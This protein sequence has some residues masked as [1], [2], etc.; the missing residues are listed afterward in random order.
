MVLA[1]GAAVAYVVAELCGSQ[2][3]YEELMVR[4]L[5]NKGN[6]AL[7]TGERNLVELAVCSGS[8]LDNKQ[9]RHVKWPPHSV[10]VDV[11]RGQEELI[12]AGDLLIHS[13]DFVY[14]LTDTEHEAT[15]RMLGQEIEAPGNLYGDF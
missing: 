15:V 13:G 14:V 1:R 3:I 2:P 12:P 7:V 9:I 11:K 4:A 8:L 6:P 10:V 5:K